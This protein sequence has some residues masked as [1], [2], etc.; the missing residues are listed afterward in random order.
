MQRVCQPL[1]R[2][3]SVECNMSRV[4]SEEVIKISKTSNSNKVC[5]FNRS[6]QEHNCNGLEERD[7]YNR[8]LQTSAGCDQ[9][10]WCQ[11][12]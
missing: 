10:C 5:N 11:E 9:V 1:D 6:N 7:D 12:T 4:A 8:K 2:D 3:V